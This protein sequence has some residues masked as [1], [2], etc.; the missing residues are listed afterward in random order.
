M[1]TAITKPEQFSKPVTFKSP[2]IFDVL[3]IVKPSEKEW[4]YM[5]KELET[6]PINKGIK[7][8]LCACNFG[9]VWQYLYTEECSYFF[10]WKR[11]CHVF[12]HRFHPKKNR[13]VK[14]LIPASKT[15][16]K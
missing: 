12:R 15:Y 5:W 4:D 16:L 14:L 11:Q 9:E 2:S 8:P 13:H 7:E 10:F 1:S 3:D 6:H